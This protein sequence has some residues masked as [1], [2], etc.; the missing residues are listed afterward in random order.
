LHTG[1][2]SQATLNLYFRTRGAL[3]Q[4]E[5]PSMLFVSHAAVAWCGAVQVH[6]LSDALDRRK[7]IGQAIG[8]VMERY[9]VGETAAFAFLTRAS[10]TGNVKLRAVA[11]R[12]VAESA[13]SGAAPMQK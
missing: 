8:I 3:E 7:T 10:Q 6:A 11:A 2:N 9:A 4:L 1:S 5:L 13:K 12:I